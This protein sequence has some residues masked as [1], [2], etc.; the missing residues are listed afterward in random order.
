MPVFNYHLCGLTI[1]TPFQFAEL[2]VSKLEPDVRIRF[3]ACYVP[4]KEKIKFE[5]PFCKVAPNHV[6]FDLKN[7]AK[8]MV[9]DGREIVI[10]QSYSQDIHALKAF[11]LGCC[12][13]VLLT[14][15]QSLVLHAS[16]L[17]KDGT[18]VAFAGK[19][20]AGK[21]TLAAQLLENDFRLLTDNIAVI[22]FTEDQP[23]VVPSFPQIHLWKATLGKLGL[24]ETLFHRI[25]PELEKYARTLTEEQF[26]A[27]P[28]RLNTICILCPWN[29]RDIHCEVVEGPEK[30][31]QLIEM[32][33]RLKITKGL[34][35]EK[36]HFQQV[37]ELAK[38]INVVKLFYAQ[39]WELNHH[40]MNRI[41][42]EL[43]PRR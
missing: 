26:L 39:D 43:F 31:F 1:E 36:S 9:L 41:E 5:G 33:F 2:P 40:L 12:L 19:G 4:A 3:G 15:R 29:K 24:Q 13:G 10:D 11:I 18:S 38:H 20:G 14:Q 34:G 32:S 23:Q 6:L 22:N 8:L 42:T 28:N 16:V 27:I 35:L 7:I 17:E 37:N 25:R 21:S 30:V